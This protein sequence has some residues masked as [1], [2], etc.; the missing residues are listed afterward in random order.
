M[1]WAA[2]HADVIN[3][4]QGVRSGACNAYQTSNYDYVSR[5]LDYWP[6]VGPYP[7]VTKSAGNRGVDKVSSGSNHNG[8]V[9]GGIDHGATTNR[10]NHKI[11]D[12]AR[13]DNCEGADEATCAANGCVARYE[14]SGAPHLG[15]EEQDNQTDCEALSSWCGW[16]FV[17]C[18]GLGSQGRNR[19]ADSLEVPHV[20]APAKEVLVLDRDG[21]WRERTGTSYAAPHV[22]GIAARVL[23]LAPML[24]SY[25]EAVRAIILATATQDVDGV[26]LRLDDLVDDLDGAGEVDALEAERVADP[27]S[28]FHQQWCT[29]A[30]PCQDRGVN[31]GYVSTLTLDNGPL[32]PLFF[33]G[34]SGADTLQIAFT[35]MVNVSCA[36]GD[37]ECTGEPSSPLRFIIVLSREVPTGWQPIEYS[38]VP[39]EGNYLF[40]RAATEPGGRY[41]LNV[42]PDPYSG[43]HSTYYGLAWT[44][45]NQGATQ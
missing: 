26:S 25:P 30:N 23:Q 21:A 17:T 24:R 27:A 34:A 9:L 12:D 36:P 37:L 4:S 22:A 29:E 16:H 13:C 28:S 33:E 35:W 42:F 43:F 45:Y 18:Y 31:W 8:L 5:I 41:M 19:T 3:V 11:W 14:C 39:G 15:C 7:V 38:W 10:A 40:I 2:L 44:T 32:G 1:N 6:T 20:V